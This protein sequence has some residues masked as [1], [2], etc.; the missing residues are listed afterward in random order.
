MKK[1]TKEAFLRFLGL[2][3][4][5]AEPEELERM[6][7]DATAVLAGEPEEKTVDISP[8]PEAPAGDKTVE[9][10]TE[11]DSLVEKLDQI[12]ELLQD[13]GRGGEGGRRLHDESDLDEL[14]AKLAGKEEGAVTV[15]EEQDC[16]GMDEA[17]RQAAAAILR[18]ARPAVAGIQD[19]AEKAR[20]TDA[21]LGAIRGEDQVSAVVRA[22]MDS[23]RA[24]A[25][26]TGPASYER[27]CA[28]AQAAYDAR[29]PH[30]TVKED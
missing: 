16:G 25:V 13:R 19:P 9:K 27:L 23:A 26:G 1:E 24:R 17:T 22:A 11:G 30:K 14:L 12:L 29:N 8:E 28:D 4:R 18:K 21:L 2:A 3:A 7:Q 10:S 20:V 15:P 6:T 5:D